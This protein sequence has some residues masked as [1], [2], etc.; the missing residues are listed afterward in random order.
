[1]N[2][3]SP[4]AE[5]APRMRMPQ[6]GL[7]AMLVMVALAASGFMAVKLIGPTN[8]AVCGFALLLVAAH[9]L[10]NCVGTRLKSAPPED[11][12]GPDDADR[13]ASGK[14][15]APLPSTRL[16]D[17]YPVN[18][19]MISVTGVA[20]LIGGGIGTFALTHLLGPGLRPHELFVGGASAAVI[21]GFFGFLSSSFFE[22]FWHAWRESAR[23]DHRRMSEPAVVRAS[24]RQVASIW[25]G[26]LVKLFPRETRPLPENPSS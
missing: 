12:R 15:S 20:A 4:S 10:G 25:K 11:G 8:S 5:Q 1:M 16:R 14:P 3:E 24:G 2:A 18:R 9:V 22:V 21:F 6:F 19:L 13:P 23:V 17:D 26:L 7:R